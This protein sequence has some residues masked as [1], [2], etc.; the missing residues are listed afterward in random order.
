MFLAMQNTYAFVT[1]PLASNIYAS[2][3]KQAQPSY[4]IALRIM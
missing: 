2:N 1:N 3:K 4:L